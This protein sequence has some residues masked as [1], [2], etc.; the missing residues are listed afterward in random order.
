M[1][2]PQPANRLTVALALADSW[3]AIPVE[4]AVNG[5]DVKIGD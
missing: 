2:L 5:L 3:G 4:V 1:T